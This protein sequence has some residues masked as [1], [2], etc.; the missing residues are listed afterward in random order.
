[1]FTNSFITCLSLSKRDNFFHT[2]TQLT[3][4]LHDVIKPLETF[5]LNGRLF[6]VKNRAILV[7][8]NYVLDELTHINCGVLLNTVESGFLS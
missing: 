5:L 7:R 8:Y 6:S 3:I 2:D 1:V 4:N